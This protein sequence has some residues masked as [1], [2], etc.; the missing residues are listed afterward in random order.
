MDR[1]KHLSYVIDQIKMADS[2]ANFLLAFYVVLTGFLVKDF[3]EIWHVLQK[4]YGS[5]CILFTALVLLLGWMICLI[6]KFFYYFTR[7][8]KPRIDPKKLLKKDDYVSII[9]WGDIANNLKKFREAN[10]DDFQDDLKDQIIANS[11]VANQKFQ[12]VSKVYD[13]LPLTVGVYILLK[14]LLTVLS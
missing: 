8:V 5:N 11:V 12:Y 2:K 14:V 6:V 1:W 3:P 10:Q 13:L 4:H 9:F 7:V